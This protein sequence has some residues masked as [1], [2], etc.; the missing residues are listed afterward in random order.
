MSEIAKALDAMLQDSGE[1]SGAI[2]MRPDYLCIG[3]RGVAVPKDASHFAQAEK[4]F[5]SDGCVSIEF[6]DYLVTLQKGQGV[7]IGVYRPK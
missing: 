6:K 2:A 3:A 7:I 1:L 5:D 4:L